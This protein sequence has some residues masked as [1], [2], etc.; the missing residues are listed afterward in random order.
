MKPI[1]DFE[2][3]MFSLVEWFFFSDL[4]SGDKKKNT[5]NYEFTDNFQ[6]FFILI[7]PEKKTV[8]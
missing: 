2:A 3:R 5:E 8:N 6:S 1:C 7:S 4:G